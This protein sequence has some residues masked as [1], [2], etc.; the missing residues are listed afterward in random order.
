[1][2][3]SPL[4][5]IRGLKTYFFTED[6]VVR[7]VDYIDL[8]VNRSEIVGLV[9]ESGCGKSTVALS[10]LRLIPYP[11]KIVSGEI[12]FDGINLLTLNEDEMRKIRGGRISIIFQNPQTSLNPVF[13]IG[14]QIAEAVKL[15]QKISKN[16]EIRE[17]VINI[18]EKVGFSDPERQFELFPHELSGGMQQRVMIAMALSCRPDLLIADEPTTSL[19]VTIQAQIL[20]L[21]KNLQ[22]EFKSSILLITHNMGVVAEL[23]DKV[24]VMY[25]GKIVEYG[26]IIAVFKNPLHPYTKAL[27]Q[28]VPRIDVEEQKLEGI[29]GTVP[30]LINPPSGC[31]FHPRC[32]YFMKVC[33][34]KKPSKFEVE[35]NHF[36]YCHLFE[37][38]KF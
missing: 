24:A 19:D 13:K 5:S 23:C 28:S 4:L 15:H 26:D 27:L 12:I 1:M 30:S 10:I 37:K 2:S 18:L 35:K 31:R 14:Y 32:K 21:M 22:K 3:S 17:R 11:G 34:E 7:A 8:D 25:A 16:E 36:V 6:G 29:P 9:G 38:G 33:K 20:E